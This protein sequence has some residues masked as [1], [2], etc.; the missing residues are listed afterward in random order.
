MSDDLERLEGQ[1][2]AL[3][4]SVDKLYGAVKAHNEYME[5]VRSE[6]DKLLKSAGPVLSMAAPMFQQMM[7]GNLAMPTP[8]QPA[9]QTPA[10]ISGGFDG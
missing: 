2:Q 7:S 3:T 9:E 10:A 4:A 1:V 5:W 6:M 8:T